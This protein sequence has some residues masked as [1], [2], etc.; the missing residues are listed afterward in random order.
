MT[1]II[2]DDFPA[3][4][5]CSLNQPCINIFYQRAGN[6]ESQN[7]YEAENAVQDWWIILHPTA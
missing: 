4:C 1:T 5:S 2:F 3:A 6:Q 7:L